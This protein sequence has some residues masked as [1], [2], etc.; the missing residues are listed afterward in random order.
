MPTASQ[1]VSNEA[2]SQSITSNQPKHGKGAMGTCTHPPPTLLPP[3]PPQ[4]SNVSFRSAHLYIHVSSFAHT[5]EIKNYT[6]CSII[7]LTALLPVIYLLFKVFFPGLHTT[8]DCFFSF[9]SL[10]LPIWIL[11]RTDRSLIH[12]RCYCCC[13]YCCYCFYCCSSLGS[14]AIGK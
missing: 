2:A 7:S 3:Q 8:P 14:V 1:P 11:A 4:Y 13:C 10:G 9:V 5:R 12:T 6:E